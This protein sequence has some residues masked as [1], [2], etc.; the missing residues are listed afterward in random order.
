MLDFFFTG[1]F[2]ASSASVPAFLLCLGSSLLM[3]SLL[4]LAYSAAVRCTK[5]FAITLALLPAMVCAVILMVNG[6]VGT[7]VAVAGAFTLVR[8]RSIPGTAQEIGAVFLAMAVGL[9]AGMGY[10]GL[11]L[12]FLLV[13]GG[14]AA[15]LGRLD[16]GASRTKRERTLHI[17]IPESL[18]YPH[19]F[20]DIWQQYTSAWELAQVKTTNLGS[21]FKLTYHVTL[22]DLGQEKALLDEL[23]CRNGNLEITVGPQSRESCNL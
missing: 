14:A 17:T 10:L 4:A 1:L 22:L 13:V 18:D 16:F 11:G 5:G 19:L 12:L 20:D 15:L 3:G 6:N 9:M 2:D 7:G 8:F 21:M 23:R